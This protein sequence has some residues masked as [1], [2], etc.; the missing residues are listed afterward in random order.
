MSLDT[1]QFIVLYCACNGGLF[2]QCGT[3][4][5]WLLSEG[6]VGVA[7]CRSGKAKKRGSTQSAS[8]AGTAATATTYSFTFLKSL[9]STPLRS[10]EGLWCTCVCVCVCVCMCVCECVCVCVCVCVN[11]CECVCVC[12]CVCVYVCSVCM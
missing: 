3:L 5:P 9:T 11:V 1:T 4:V 7:V 6:L 12:V 2:S 8:E 10:C